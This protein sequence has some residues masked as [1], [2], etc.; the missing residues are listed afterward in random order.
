MT[1]RPA[2][3]GLRLIIA[4]KVARAVSALSASGAI[5]AVKL[6]GHTA[7]IFSTA[8]ALRQHATSAWSVALTEALLHVVTPRHLWLA[9]G[10]LALDGTFTALEGWALHLGA[11]WG[12]WLVVVATCTFIPFEV[13]ALAH[14]A[15]VVRALVLLFNVII[16]LYLFRHAARKVR[17]GDAA[18]VSPSRDE[19]SSPAVS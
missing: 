2:E 14:H 7:A 3:T 18:S 15:S 19:P 16:A 10:A 5:V 1:E 17:S 4:Y 9:A 11:T 13:L 6:T 12:E 8:E